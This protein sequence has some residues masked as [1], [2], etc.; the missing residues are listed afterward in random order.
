MRAWVFGSE[1]RLATA[2]VPAPMR[3][4]KLDSPATPHPHQPP[5][6]RLVEIACPLKSQDSQ[7]YQASWPGS[8]VLTADEARKSIT[9]DFSKELRIGCRS[10]RDAA[11]AGIN[12]AGRAFKPE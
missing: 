4:S 7:I 3:T 1:V 10:D 12:A 8:R 9:H 6:R 5:R 2:K 11:V